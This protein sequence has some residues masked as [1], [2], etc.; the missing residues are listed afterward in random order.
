MNWNIIHVKLAKIGKSS[1]KT[2]D[3]FCIDS[4]SNQPLLTVVLIKSFPCLYIEVDLLI[5]TFMLT[6]APRLSRVLAVV[7]LPCLAARC[8]GVLPPRSI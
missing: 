3:D 1:N 7:V 6:E 2:V 8:R 5:Y 4:S